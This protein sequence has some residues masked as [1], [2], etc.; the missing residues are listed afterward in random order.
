MIPKKASTQPTAKDGD[1]EQDNTTEGEEEDTSPAT[2]SRDP[3]T[4][5][6]YVSCRAWAVANAQSGKLLGESAAD[7]VVDV[8]STTKIMTADT[9][10]A[11]LT[12][13][14]HLGCDT[15]M[16]SSRLP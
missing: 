12:F 10:R 14:H 16:V 4:G 13:N 15:R 1:G 8:A 11:K 3:L 9:L 7:R 2:N 6:P 5:P